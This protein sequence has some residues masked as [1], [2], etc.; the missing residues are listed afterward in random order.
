VFEMLLKLL[1][2]QVYPC[3]IW[4]LTLDIKIYK[5]LYTLLPRR[6][7]LPYL[8]TYRVYSNVIIFKIIYSFAIFFLYIN[9][10]KSFYSSHFSSFLSL[11]LV[12]SIGLFVKYKMLLEKYKCRWVCIINCIQLKTI[13]LNKKK[14]K[15]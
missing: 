9:I 14:C 3:F 15:T 5:Y 13:C 11:D 12:F 7:I 8:C 4:E 6:T 10:S 2:V 1:E